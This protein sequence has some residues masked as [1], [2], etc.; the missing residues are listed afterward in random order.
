MYMYMYI[1]MYTYM[2]ARKQINRT[3]ERL[4]VIV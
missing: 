3:K 1:Y 4:A 2:Y